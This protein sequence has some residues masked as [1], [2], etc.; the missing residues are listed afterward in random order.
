VFTLLEKLALPDFK[1]QC[2]QSTIRHLVSVH[3]RYS[4]LGQW[5]GIET[6]DIVYFDS[7]ST[8][9][10]LLIRHGYLT[11]ETWSRRTPTYYIEVKTTMG[12]VDRPFFCSQPQF[13]RMEAHELP[14]DGNGADDIYLIA[15]VFGVG[16]SQMGLK[17]Y[18][19]PWKMRRNRELKFEAQVYSVTAC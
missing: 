18:L 15:R 9:T 6:S 5:S 8:L 11:R 1:R 14:D 13:D 17:L 12:D 19:D 16:R 7:E 3:E 4:D 2:W 10:D